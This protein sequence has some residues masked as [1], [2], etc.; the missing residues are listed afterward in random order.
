MALNCLGPVEHRVHLHLLLAL[1]LCQ[2]IPEN[3]VVTNIQW[4]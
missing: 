3:L 1:F 4:L 2:L